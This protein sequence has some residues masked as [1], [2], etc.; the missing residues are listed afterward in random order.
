MKQKKLSKK[1]Q[2]RCE[3]LYKIGLEMF[4]ERGYEGTSLS[5]VVKIAGGSLS[6]IYQQF[7]NKEDFFEAVFFKGIEEFFGNIEKKITQATDQSIENF[8]YQ[9]GREYIEFFCDDNTISLGRVMYGEGYKDNGKLSKL[10]MSRIANLN[11]KIFL[12][13]FEANNAKK[14]L[15]IDDYETLA[16]EFC[17]LI[18]EPEFSNAILGYK[19]TKMTAKQKED[20]I[21]RTVEFFLHGYKKS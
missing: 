11:K 10:F 2:A 7:G 14:D 6:T 20:K 3:M 13:Y 12:D 18:R 1:T 17:L 8:L 9:F 5:E 19:T 21:K 15:K 16:E 4:L